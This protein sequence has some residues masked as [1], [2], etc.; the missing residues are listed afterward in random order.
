MVSTGMRTDRK[1]TIVILGMNS[2]IIILS[3]TS[4]ATRGRWEKTGGDNDPTDFI[5]DSIKRNITSISWISNPVT[6]WTPI[7]THIISD[8][9]GIGYIVG[10]DRYFIT[11]SALDIIVLW[12]RIPSVYAG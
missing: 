11:E 4:M 10:R 1:K 12:L 7:S 6:V 8:C 5:L 2:L 9:I 3:L